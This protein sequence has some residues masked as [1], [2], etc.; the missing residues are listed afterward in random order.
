MGSGGVAIAALPTVICLKVP[1]S[2]GLGG[3][4]V[5]LLTLERGEK[6]KY[7]GKRVVRSVK[8]CNFVFENLVCLFSFV[9][10]RR[11]GGSIVWLTT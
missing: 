8:R 3:V 5:T 9:W 1:F 2:D 4:C 6:Q 7:L 10:K 11:G